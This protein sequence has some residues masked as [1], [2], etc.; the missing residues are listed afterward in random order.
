MGKIVSWTVLEMS[1]K[2]TN[3][4]ADAIKMMIWRDVMPTTCAYDTLKSNAWSMDDPSAHVL[5]YRSYWFSM[6]VVFTL[7]YILGWG[8][9]CTVAVKN[10]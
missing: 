2:K 1:K 10:I 4:S 5:E 9:L 7:K 6:S 8:I 3:P